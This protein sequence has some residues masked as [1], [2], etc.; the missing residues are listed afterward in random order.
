MNGELERNDGTD[1]AQE[2]GWT[3]VSACNL[4][5]GDF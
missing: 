2:A 3:L 4:F 1:S 5:D